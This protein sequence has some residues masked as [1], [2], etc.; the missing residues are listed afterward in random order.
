MK[1]RCDTIKIVMEVRK[2]A[3]DKVPVRLRVWFRFSVG[4]SKDPIYILKN[5][6]PLEVNFFYNINPENPS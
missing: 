4:S 5:I 1:Q 3:S 6:F 2:T